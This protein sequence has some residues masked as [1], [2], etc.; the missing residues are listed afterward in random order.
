MCSYSNINLRVNSKKVCTSVIGIHS[1][2][3]RE[4]EI[5]KTFEEQLGMTGTVIILTNLAS[6]VNLATQDCLFENQHIQHL[7]NRAR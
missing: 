1:I 5:S 3:S 6:G 4:R 7:S 2:R